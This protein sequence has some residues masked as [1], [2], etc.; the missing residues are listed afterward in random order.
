[1]GSLMKRSTVTL[2]ALALLLV[3]SWGQK[4]L[5]QKKAAAPTPL[6]STSLSSGVVVEIA[7]KPVTWKDLRENYPHRAY[8]L[9][10]EIHQKL[11]GLASEHY[12]KHYFE[13]LGRS[14]G[15]NEEQAKEKYLLERTQISDA[16]LK[17]QVEQYKDHPQLKGKSEAEIM[18]SVRPHIEQ[19]KAGHVLRQLLQEAMLKKQFKFLWPEPVEGTYDM[20]FAADEHVRYGPEAGDIKPMGCKGDACPVTVVEYSEFQC[21]YCA[22]VLP[23]TTKIMREYKG[24]IR[25]IVRDLP[26]DFHERAVPAAIAAG[27]AGEQGKF[28]H[29]YFKLFENQRSL[30]DKDFVKYAKQLGIYNS[31]F[32]DCQA[33]PDAQM[34]RIDRNLAEARRLDVNGT[35]AFF[36]NGR[37]FSGALPYGQ[38]KT[39][40]EEELAS[41]SKAK[42]KG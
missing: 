24:K 10:K 27:C 14:S 38:F 8:Q 35:P 25:W 11:Y 15:L 39:V 1:M 33:N 3:T 40:I 26:L 28:W 31:K 4:T 36:I 2:W 23:D 19:Q 37:R 32:K 6:L 20:V 34:E 16:E 13:N 7:G 18:K 30:S 17:Q 5:G 41:R 29:M 21:P 42:G 22:R 9:E 12:L